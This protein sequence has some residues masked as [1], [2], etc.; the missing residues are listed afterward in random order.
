M[1]HLGPP[2]VLWPFLILANMGGS[3]ELRRAD[4][5]TPTSVF[6]THS[7]THA[8]P[9]FHC[10]LGNGKRGHYER[11]LFAGE[12]SRISKIS[13]FSRISRR[14]SES[15][16][17]S[18]V[19]G[20]SRISR[21]SKFSRISRKWT[22]LKRPLFQKTP[23]S[24]PDIRLCLKALFPHASVLKTHRHAVYQCLKKPPTFFRHASVFKTLA[25][26]HERV[27]F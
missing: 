2:T 14:W 5:Q 20:F 7:D 16:L 8:V 15:P 3:S 4:T 23:F 12:I 19:W 18:T 11:G 6:S 26:R 21:I 24:D 9:A 25:V 13:K 27:H 10:I 22:L 1:V 17:F